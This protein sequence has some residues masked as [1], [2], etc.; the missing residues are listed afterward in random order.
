ML[1]TV[2]AVAGRYGGRVAGWVVVNEAIDAHEA[3]G[4]RRDYPWYETVG[5]TYI[6]EA[7]RAASAADPDAILVLNEFGH[8]TDDEFDAAADKRAKTLIVLDNLLD[9]GVPVHALGVE[10]HLEADGFADKFDAD[11]YVALPGRSGESRAGDPGDRARCPRRRLAGRCHR[12]GRRDRRY[13]R[14]LPRCRLA[15]TGR[16]HRDDL[17]P[18]RP[19]HL[20]AGGLPARRRRTPPA[21]TLR[22]RPPTRS[23]PPTPSAPR[24][25]APPSGLLSGRLRAPAERRN[26]VPSFLPAFPPPVFPPRYWQTHSLRRPTDHIQA[27]ALAL[28]QASKTSLSA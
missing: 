12:T 2:E 3:D 13:L 26:P 16:G 1:G 21:A 8:E 23:P 19:L 28:A 20:A 17:W 14:P 11:A 25:R 22:R 7:F 9:A 18:D 4:L 5:P 15:G 6:E 10:A 24:W 27:A